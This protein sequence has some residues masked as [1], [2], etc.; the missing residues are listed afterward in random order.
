MMKFK[1]TTWKLLK[2]ETLE[3][4]SELDHFWAMRR[5][6]ITLRF[7]AQNQ[8]FHFFEAKMSVK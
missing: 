4:A 7:H 5:S 6:K 3:F 1:R 8:N 2:V